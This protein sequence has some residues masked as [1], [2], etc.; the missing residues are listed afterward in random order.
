MSGL[1]VRNIKLVLEYD[2]TDFHGWQRQPG[3][4]TVQGEVESA[5]EQLT[6]ARPSCNAS[7][8]TDA[9]VHALG[10]VVQFT[11]VSRLAPAVIARA[12]NASLPRDVRVLD[13]VEV[14]QAFHATL[15]ALSKCY[16]Y[17][18]DN[19]PIA[20]PFLR[21]HAWHVPWRLDVDAMRRAAQSL[22]GRHDFRSFETEWPNRTSSVRT[23]FDAAA[24]RDGDTVN[25][26][27]EA[28]GFLYNMVR[29]IAGTLMYVGKGKRSVAWVAEVL[30]A[31]DRR[32][33]GPTA[34]PQGL[35]LVGVRYE[36]GAGANP[37][38]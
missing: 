8:R 2:G 9:G 31:R 33:A 7:G 18:I 28:D 37:A 35:Y 15:D 22:L 17:V 32:A 13:A 27:V 14:P 4:R 26:E 24:T 38:P 5:L 34:P 29:T 19:R 20:R 11:T 21:R 10:Q 23:L 6:G 25:V 12:L 3:L 30:A 16:R 1:C 36:D